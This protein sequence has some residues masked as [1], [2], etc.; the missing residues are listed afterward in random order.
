MPRFFRWSS[1]FCLSFFAIDLL[2]DLFLFMP[3]FFRWSSLFCSFITHSRGSIGGMGVAPMASPLVSD[4]HS[5]LSPMMRAVHP[6]GI[7]SRRAPAAVLVLMQSLLYRHPRPPR[8]WAWPG[9]P[10]HWPP[11][12]SLQ[13]GAFPAPW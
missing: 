2:M 10:G 11:L 8:A 4:F 12:P 9:L 1:L 13:V 7:H 3:R 6:H 5:F